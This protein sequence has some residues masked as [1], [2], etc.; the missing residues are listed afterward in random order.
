MQAKAHSKDV[1]EL[2]KNA[3]R[4]GA[5]EYLL[6]DVKS[7]TVIDR[8]SFPWAYMLLIACGILLIAVNTWPDSLPD[9]VGKILVVGAMLTGSLWFLLVLFGNRGPRY[10][11]RLTV[12]SGEVDLVV[13]RNL[14]DAR[15]LAAKIQSLLTIRQDANI[16]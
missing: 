15:T 3:I 4:V 6:A 2:N 9:L 10:S 7:A 16:D 13:F 14:S 5:A 11:V 8:K 12:S 1:I